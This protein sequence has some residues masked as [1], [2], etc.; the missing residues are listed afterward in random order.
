MKG[1]NEGR[2]GGKEGRLHERRKKRP[3]VGGKENNEVRGKY[4][5]L[6]VKNTKKKLKEK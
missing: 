3:N 5:R 4:R 1:R 2:S 6:E